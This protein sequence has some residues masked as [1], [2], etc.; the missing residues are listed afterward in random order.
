[1][2]F[3]VRVRDKRTLPI[4]LFSG[5][6][7]YASSVDLTVSCPFGDGRLSNDPKG[8]TTPNDALFGERRKGCKNIEANSMHEL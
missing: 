2:T 5:E 6:T 8:Q 7:T 3:E 1:M 4:S